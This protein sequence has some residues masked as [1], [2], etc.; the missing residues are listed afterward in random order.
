[1]KRGKKMNRKMEI[2]RW[3]EKHEK[4]N[5]TNPFSSTYTHK[6]SCGLSLHYLS[7]L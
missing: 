6:K 5:E 3:I 4:N 7:I 1:M 2:E